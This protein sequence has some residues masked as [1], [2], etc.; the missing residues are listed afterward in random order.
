ML[1]IPILNYNTFYPLD[2]A[3]TPKSHPFITYPIP[4]VN[5]KG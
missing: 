5:S 4:N 1:I 2:I 3:A